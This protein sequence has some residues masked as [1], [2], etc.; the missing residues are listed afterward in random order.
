MSGQWRPDLMSRI[1]GL[2]LTDLDNRVADVQDPVP[3]TSTI[4]P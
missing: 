3:V 1:Q 2:L 4:N